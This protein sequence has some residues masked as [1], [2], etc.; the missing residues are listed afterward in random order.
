MEASDERYPKRTNPAKMTGFVSSLKYEVLDGF[1]SAG[2]A[3]VSG[4]P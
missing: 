3:M 2:Q 4:I 1:F